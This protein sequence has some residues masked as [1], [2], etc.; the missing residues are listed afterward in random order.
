MPRVCPDRPR[1]PYIQVTDLI[2][3]DAGGGLFE[4]QGDTP[5][6]KHV[7]C[8]TR[9]TVDRNLLKIKDISTVTRK[10]DVIK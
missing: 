9:V 3:F 5:L 10:S 1:C 4:G 8:V 7:T 2:G 6:I